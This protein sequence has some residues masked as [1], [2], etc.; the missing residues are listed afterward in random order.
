MAPRNIGYR[1]QNRA[2]R[3]QRSAQ[4]CRRQRRRSD[5]IVGGVRRVIAR[6]PPRAS[7]VV[8]VERSPGPKWR[9]SPMASLTFISRSGAG[10]HKEK[11]QCESNS[12][13]DSTRMAGG[14]FRGNSSHRPTRPKRCWQIAGGRMDSRNEQL[15]VRGRAILQTVV[16]VAPMG[17]GPTAAPRRKPRRKIRDQGL[18]LLPGSGVPRLSPLF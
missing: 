2:I 15:A 17:I 12:H 10:D 11:H 8:T 1:V 5:R 16:I 4:R 7:D 6:I 13:E 14:W 3:P 9:E 18:D